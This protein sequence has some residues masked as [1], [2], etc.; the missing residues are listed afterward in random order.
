MGPKKTDWFTTSVTETL[1][2]FSVDD[3]AGLSDSEA[4]KIKEEKGANVLAAKKKKS[5]FTILLSQLNDWLIY[6][7]LAAV[8]ITFFMGE[9]VDAVIILL[10]ITLNGAIGTFQ[11]IKAGKAIDALMKM[12]S[13]KALVKRS[14]QTKEID[15]T[16]IV[17]GDIIILDAGRV[18]PADLRLIE[19]VNLQIEESSLTGESLPVTKNAEEVFENSKLP[20]AERQNMAFMSTIV[21]AGRG[22]GVAVGTGMNTEVGKIADLLDTDVHVKTPLEK[23]LSEL[24]K[25]LGKVAVG[26]CLVIF[27]V[28]WLQG[29]DLAEMFLIS[30]SLSQ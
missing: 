18:I 25:T 1:S 24:G 21:T 4:S 14:G 22:M 23:K 16:E 28:S 11:E 10:V 13:P 7:L 15:S 8:V 29:R 17:P 9:Y 12:S 30:V 3:G 6:V 5:I 26:I 2:H 27:G 20:L 19:T